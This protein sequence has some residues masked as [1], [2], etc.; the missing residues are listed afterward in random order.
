MAHPKKKTSLSRKR[1]RRIYENN[2][3]KKKIPLLFFNKNFKF[4]QRYHYLKIYKTKNKKIYY[5]KNKVIKKI[6]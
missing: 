3:I 6:L 4:Y 5:Y 2:N 1:K